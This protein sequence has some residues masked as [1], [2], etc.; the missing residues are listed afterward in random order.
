VTVNPQK[1][2]IHLR[3][4][5]QFSHYLI[6]VTTVNSVAYILINAGRLPSQ[7]L[8]AILTAVNALGAGVAQAV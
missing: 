3:K 1:H 4:P 6:S 7:V 8:L 5:S 2:K